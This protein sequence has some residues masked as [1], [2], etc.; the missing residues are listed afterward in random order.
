MVEIGIAQVSK[1]FGS[2]RAVDRVSLTVATGELFFLLGPSGCG[3]TT[4]LRLVAGFEHPD[5][6]HISF[7]GKPVDNVP[8]ELRNTG[9]VF[10]NYALWPHLNV[11]RN[12][13]YGLEVRGVP[14]PERRRRVQEA[15]DLVRL[16]GFDHRFPSE[17]SGGQQQR[18]ALA[19]ALVIDPDAV[20]LD[21]P[22]SNLD[23]KLRS[24]MRREIR[25]IH[26]QTRATMLYVTH[27]QIEALSLADR[28]AVMR[29]GRLEQLGSP[30]D[31]YRSPGNPFVASFVGKA[32]LLE[33]TISSLTNDLAVVDTLLGPV[34][35]VPCPGLCPGARV[36]CAIRAESL[37]LSPPGPASPPDAF[38]VKVL[39]HTYQGDTV[40]YE[41]AG[42]AGVELV[43][44]V[45][46]NADP[47]LRPGD[48]ASVT[49]SPDQVCL[50]PK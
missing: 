16:S 39:T 2:T 46:G 29:D 49:F 50:M 31:L 37:S 17:L 5:S 14:R 6:G 19:R 38:P 47:G 40:Q 1:S 23:A 15:L 24:D 27:D 28:I 43:S 26:D 45:M 32:T 11:F 35:A 12:V 48:S 3:K 8:P 9:M 41:L 44:L 21:E 7:N 18:V 30:R 42:S 13:S 34:R 4:L 20:L 22:L 25:R 36:V 10:Q 33:G